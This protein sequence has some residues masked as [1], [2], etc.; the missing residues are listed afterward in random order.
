MSL[1]CVVVAAPLQA[2]IYFAAGIEV[3]VLALSDWKRLLVGEAPCA[4]LGEVLIRAL[5]VYVFLLAALRLMGKRMGGQVSNLELSVMV[6]LGAIAAVPIQVV[7]RGILPALV[8]LLCVLAMQRSLAALGTRSK[9]FE[10]LTQGKPAIM[11]ADG[12]IM[13]E[14]LE[15]SRISQR[16][17]FSTLRTEGVRHLGEIKRVYLE[18]GGVFSIIR[19]PKPKPGLPVLPSFDRNQEQNTRAQSDVRACTNCGQV[20][21]LGTAS[22]PRCRQRTWSFAVA[23]SAPARADDHRAGVAEC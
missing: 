13:L 17:I 11:V 7:D 1:V 20:S 18:T 3:R 9:R 2:G 8:L 22:C 4:F 14:A 21:A 5:I 12:V 6:T 19:A 15:K 23:V 16:Q 10:E